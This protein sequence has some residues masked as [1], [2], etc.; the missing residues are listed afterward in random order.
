MPAYL[1]LNLAA[2]ASVQEGALNWARLR[3]SRI[4]LH[5]A[6]FVFFAGLGVLALPTGASG[7]ATVSSSAPA[8]AD[9]DYVP[10]LTFDVASIHEVNRDQN[11]GVRVSV[12]SPPHTSKFTATTFTTKMLLQSAYGWGV[13]IATGPDWMSQTY[14]N[15][16]AK[17]DPSVDAQMAKLTDDQAK[18]EKMHMLQALL[19]DRF[20]L[21]SH[22]ETK[23][24]SVYALTLAKSGTKLH[25]VKVDADDPDRPTPANQGVDVQ[26]HGSSQGLEFVVHSASMRAI[27]ALLSSQVEAPVLDRTGLTGYFDFTLQI[28]REWSAGDSESWPSIFTAL[29]EQLGLK[30]EPAKAAVPNLIIDHIEKPSAN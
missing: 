3:L 25:Q 10:T 21:K 13:P 17:S 23:E 14:F 12:S 16:E 1:P 9:T 11:G 19:A 7:Q 4:G 22:L 5:V 2:L 6:R 28:G 26:A 20:R 24:S 27:T 18:L 8:A 29:Q 30:L 15:I